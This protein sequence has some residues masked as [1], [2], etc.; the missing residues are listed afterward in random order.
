MEV[1]DLVGLSCRRDLLVL[2]TGAADD[3]ERYHHAGL[4][5]GQQEDEEA[6]ICHLC[7]IAYS[8]DGRL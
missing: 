7:S 4:V 5:N 1:L 6:Y 3:Q 8:R 2:T